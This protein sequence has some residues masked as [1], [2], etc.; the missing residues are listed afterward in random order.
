MEQ[1]LSLGKRE[2]DVV[3]KRAGERA[4]VIT[5]S[6]DG[7]KTANTYTHIHTRWHTPNV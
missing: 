2:A 7:D 3:I 6:S 5:V 4:V 1:E